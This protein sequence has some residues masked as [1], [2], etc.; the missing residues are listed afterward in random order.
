MK[1]VEAKFSKLSVR[2]T[3]KKLRRRDDQIAKLKEE[4]TERRRIEDRLKQTE[5]AAEK[6]RINLVYAKK[7]S[8]SVAKEMEQ[9]KAQTRELDKAVTEL[10]SELD[11]VQ[12]ER[13]FLLQSVAE[14]ESCTFETKQHKQ[15]YLDNVRQCCIELLS[16]NV[17]I[18][19][20]EPVIRSVK[21]V[22]GLVVGELP[23]SAT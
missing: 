9:L 22:A 11:S 14:L 6:R 3:N 18:K 4:V 1:E 2:N 17:G 20:V 10:H 23:Q 15:K 13:E 12:D 21:H 7:K 5:L 16:M 19:N 8:V